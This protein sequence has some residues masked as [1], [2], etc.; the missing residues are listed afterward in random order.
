MEVYAEQTEPLTAVY[1]EEGKLIQVDGM[2]SVEDV[3][4]RLLSA[5]SA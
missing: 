1:R 3:T 5:L 2:G 4:A